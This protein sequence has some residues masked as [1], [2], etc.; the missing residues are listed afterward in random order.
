M[1]KIG[2]KYKIGYDILEAGPK[3]RQLL[4]IWHYIGIKDNYSWNK[5]LAT[6]LREKHKIIETGEL[7]EFTKSKST[8]WFCKRLAK[9][10]INK[11]TERLRSGKEMNQKAL[12]VLTEK[13][14]DLNPR[15]DIIKINPRIID[16][17]PPEE[18]I[19]IFGEYQRY[20][21]RNNKENNFLRPTIKINQETIKEEKTIWIT[22]ILEKTIK[23]QEEK[24]RGNKIVVGWIQKDK[25][26]E[27]ETYKFFEIEKETPKEEMEMLLITEATKEKGK[28]TII[29]NLQKITMNIH[30]K[31]EQWEQLDYLETKNKKI[32]R[33]LEYHIR[34][35]EGE[36][37]LGPPRDTSDIKIL[38]ELEKTISKRGDQNKKKLKKEVIPI[39]YRIEGA[40]IRKLTQKTTYELILQEK[41]LK[42]GG[43]QTQ[44]RIEDTCKEH[45]RKTKNKIT[46]KDIW[47]GIKNKRIPFKV[48]DFIWKLIHNCH[49]VGDWFKKIP[50]W[51]DKATCEY[52]EIETMNYIL[53]ECEKN[54]SIWQEAE[55]IWKENN[56]D[57]K[58]IRPNV[59]VIRELGAIQLK[60]QNRIAPEWL[61]ERYIEIVAETIWMIWNIRN[62]RIFNNIRLTREE[63]IKKWEETMSIK[64]ETEKTLINIEDE[65]KK[66]IEMQKDFNKKWKKNNK[67]KDK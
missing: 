40:E 29:T 26:N 46:S 61:N 15:T 43:E 39:E 3:P 2:R 25:T 38:E 45:K 62:K 9:R 27:E 36:I 7:D 33:N 48:K 55:K 5:T 11:I 67:Q 1:I 6:C 59:E 47:T 52:G 53:V 56:K 57:F 58:W 19:R 20:K 51:Q 32:W 12:Q 66:R 34:K 10:I 54:K 21:K 60:E 64:L 50:N 63:A 24:T 17:R 44:K 31:M 41:N 37:L 18:A 14:D 13:R 16:N 49:K 8:Y 42:P 28:V 22:E 35:H 23:E 30:D 4:P 65:K